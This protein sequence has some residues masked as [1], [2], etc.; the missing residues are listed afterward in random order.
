MKQRFFVPGLLALALA[1]IIAAFAFHENHEA[2]QNVILEV[3]VQ[4]DQ[5]QIISNVTVFVS[6][7]GYVTSTTD[8]YGIARL[9]VKTGKKDV[10]IV[11]SSGQR[12]VVR[13][14]AVS[15]ETKLETV[16]IPNQ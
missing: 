15:T 13:S 10:G 1:P 8:E 5:R 14:V 9:A 2:V 11:T 16:T 6:G 3:K 12:Q 7:D 4:N